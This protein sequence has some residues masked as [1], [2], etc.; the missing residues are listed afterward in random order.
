MYLYYRIDKKNI[1]EKYFNLK[2]HIKINRKKIKL[3]LLIILFGIVLISLTYNLNLFS[4]KPSEDKLVVAISPFY[5]E[6][7]GN[8]G[9]DDYISKNLKERLEAENNP[10]IKIIILDKLLDNPPIRNLEDAKFQGKRNGAHL[11]VYG[12]IK[13]NTLGIIEIKYNILPTSSLEVIPSDIQFLENEGTEYSNSFI[14]GKYTFSFGIDE[15]ITIIESL[16]ENASSVVYGIGALENYE[17][18]KFTLAIDFFNSIKNYENNS[19]ILFYIANSYGYNNELQKSLLYFNKAIE[20]NPRNV[21]AWKN[22]GAILIKLKRYEEGLDASNKAIGINPQ[23]AGALNNKGIALD[24]LGRHEEALVAYDKAIGINELDA[25]T[26]CNKC[27]AFANLAMYEEA[28]YSCDKATKINPNFAEAWFNKGVA[29]DKWGKYN[30]SISAYNKA[31]EIDQQFA[32]AWNNKGVALSRWGKYNESISAYNKAIE[33]DHQY[34][35]PWT[36]KGALFYNLGNY[37]DALESSNKA[38]DLNLLDAGA[39]KIKVSALF[40]LGRY[41]ESLKDNDRAINLNSNDAE[42]WNL[43][44]ST[45]GNLGRYE[46]ALISFDKAIEINPNFAEAWRHKGLALV[47]LGRN[48]EANEAFERAR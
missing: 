32:E 30:E 1:D 6:D 42:L 7:S 11:V 22:K 17:K 4:T 10:E 44:G 20:T 2:K 28:I 5:S 29:F 3:I 25:G 39:W 15:P 43:K 27:L 24:N 18:S 14:T 48:E 35:K 38:I 45:L 33:I 8:I 26:W 12:E 36:N 9:Y 34:A 19:I 16:K 37:K 21:D 40:Y 47:K 46:E 13:K 31:I 23:D 41:E